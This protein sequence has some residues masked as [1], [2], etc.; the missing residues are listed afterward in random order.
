M[1]CGECYAM[2][3]YRHTLICQICVGQTLNALVI[4][5]VISSVQ[6]G[7][8]KLQPIIHVLAGFKMGEKSL[9]GV[10][11]D[12]VKRKKILP[13]DDTSKQHR[14][15]LKKTASLGTTAVLSPPN[16]TFVSSAV[17]DE[18]LSITQDRQGGYLVSCPTTARQEVTAI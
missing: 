12:C 14:R 4:Q 7:I 1:P 9:K 11:C 2:K 6:G 18:I 3:T 17:L 10:S 13:C 5:R 16:I 15:H 8:H